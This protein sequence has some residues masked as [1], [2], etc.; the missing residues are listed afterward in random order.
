MG[1]PT[2]SAASVWTGRRDHLARGRGAPGKHHQ[3]G[4]GGRNKA[5]QTAGILPSAEPQG[6]Q[7]ACFSMSNPWWPGNSVTGKWAKEET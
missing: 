1:K 4:A 3:W 5:Y 7:S 2:S 6:S